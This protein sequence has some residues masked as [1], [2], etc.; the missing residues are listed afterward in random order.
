MDKVPLAVNILSIATKR[1]ISKYIIIMNKLP[2]PKSLPKLLRLLAIT[3]PAM[4]C[5]SSLQAALLAHE[6]FSI[7]NTLESVGNAN[8]AKL[9]RNGVG[10]NGDSG[11]VAPNPAVSGITNWTSEQAYH[12]Y[13]AV[14]GDLTYPGLS[15]SGNQSFF[16]DSQGGFLRAHMDTSGAGVFSPV[17]TGSMIGS[18][19][20]T[21]FMSFIFQ[22]TGEEDADSHLDGTLSL[23]QYDGVSTYTDVLST[24][25]TWGT[26]YT[27]GGSNIGTYDEGTHLMVLRIDYL[28]GDDNVT[29]WFDPDTSLGEGQASA[30]TL[31]GD[32]QFNA[33]TIKNWR[34]NAA[35]PLANT[36]FD[37]IRFGT[38][39]ADVTAV[40]EPATAAALAGLG[41]LFFAYMRRRR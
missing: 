5:S 37:E 32:M 39:F 8:E 16:T 3:V 9:Q 26:N 29:V 21:L 19:G 40:P 27:A 33:L 15:S 31:S 34:S 14:N 41:V 1:F 17:T 7:Y 20:S 38:T 36:R 22:V 6:D 24:G 13:Y 2:T 11:Q 30:A 10:D 4:A 12:P 23:S 25:K 35:D 18:D 28:A